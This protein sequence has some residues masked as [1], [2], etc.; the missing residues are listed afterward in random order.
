[1]AYLFLS[2]PKC[3]TC[4]KAKLWLDE[5]AISYQE[6]HIVEGNPTIEEL[7]K[8]VKRSGLPIKRFFNTS[9]MAYKELQ[10]KDKLPE[11]TEEAQLEVLASNGMLIKRPLIIG[12]DI[13]IPGFKAEIW[14]D[15]L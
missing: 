7:S 12:E 8:W 3:S 14:R 2:Y 13:V 6:R 5:H 9:G 1:M 10:L 15:F 11:M 4:K